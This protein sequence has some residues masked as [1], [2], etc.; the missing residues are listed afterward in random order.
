V[1]ALKADP[2]QQVDYFDES[3]P[4]FVVR[5]SKFGK[6]SWCVVYRHAG[7]VR[8]LTLGSYPPIALVDARDMARDALRDAQKGS[9]P[10][11]QKRAARQAESFADLADAFIDRYSKKKKKSWREDQRIID[12][13]LKPKFR[14]AYARDV[15]RAQVRQLLGQPMSTSGPTI[16]DAPRLRRWHPWESVV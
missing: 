12:A 10:G 11:A 13:Y 3:L 6:K 1:N 15:T 8:R 16:F 7:K 9:D 4:G 2:R 14:H 5:V